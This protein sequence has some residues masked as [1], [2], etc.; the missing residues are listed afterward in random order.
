MKALIIVD[1]QNDFMPGGAL[2]VSGA[3]TL[4]PLI[5]RLIPLFPLVI[6]SQDW[7]PEDHVSFASSHAG[8][9]VGNVI[10]VDRHDQTLW[11]VHCVR[12]TKGAELV[13]SLNQDQVVSRFYKGTDKNVDSYSVF[14]DNARRKSTGLGDYLKS[15]PVTDLFFAGVATEY[16]VLYSALDAIDLGFN[17]FV[18][19]DACKP[20][21]LHPSDEKKAQEAII[22]KGGK[23]VY[24][25]DLGAS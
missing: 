6:T 13:S 20:I 2:G 24:S 25:K 23:I 12:N 9:Q 19:A 15:R 3:D 21:N 7:H 5:N 4:I 22:A 16:C 11:P 17:V 8:K 18:I 1:M 10:K 14:F